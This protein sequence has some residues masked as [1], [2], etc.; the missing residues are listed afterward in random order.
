MAGELNETM[1]SY[2]LHWG[3]M[4]FVLVVGPDPVQAR[5]AREFWERLEAE[6]IQLVALIANRLRGWPG[7]APPPALETAG[8]PRL[9]K[10]LAEC[11]PGLDATAAAS[12]IAR[13]AVHFAA[14]ARRDEQV[15]SDLIASLPLDTHNTHVIPLFA[16]DVHALGALRRMGGHIFGE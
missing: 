15:L 14:A 8:I 13:V 12:E 7:G 9:A 4:G 6:Q 5:R 16:E 2:I 10:A 3:E 1:R 11:D